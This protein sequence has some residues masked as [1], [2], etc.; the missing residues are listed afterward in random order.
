MKVD[1]KWMENNSLEV[2]AICELKKFQG[3]LCHK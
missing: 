2:G 1:A 3:I